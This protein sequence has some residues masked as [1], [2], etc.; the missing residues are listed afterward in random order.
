MIKKV[1]ISIVLFIILVGCSNDDAYNNAIEKGLDYIAIE[2]YKKA[3]S[4]FELALDE[5]KDDEKATAL[6]EQIGY[7]QEL[8][9][10]IEDKEWDIVDEKANEIIKIKGGSSALISKAKDAI[11]LSN[12]VQEDDKLAKDEI[13]QAELEDNDLAREEGKQSEEEKVDQIKDENKEVNH[14]GYETYHDGPYGYTIDYP[15]TFMP[16][17]A[18]GDP[19]AMRFSS[20]DGEILVYG[21]HHVTTEYGVIQAGYPNAIQELFDNE[22]YILEENDIQVAYKNVDQANNWFVLSYN[23]GEDIIYQKTISSENSFVK[24]IIAYPKESQGKYESIIE[25]VVASFTF[26]DHIK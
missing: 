14:D 4:A 2:E 10:A 20:D 11:E 22:L 9:H 24:L 1:L 6:L 25:H 26:Q 15:A 12:E 23:S 19:D 17:P 3:E 7:Y 18:Q 5:K 16:G 13:E 21:S 8:L